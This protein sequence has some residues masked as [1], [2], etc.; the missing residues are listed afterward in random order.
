MPGVTGTSTS[1][2][3]RGGERLL[4]GA[5]HLVAVLDPGRVDAV[6]LGDRGDVELGQVEAGR[7][8][9]LLD[10]GEP[11]ED[12]VLLVAH[13]QEGDRHL[14][15]DGAP[16]GA[17]RVLDRAL[18]D[19]A[20]DRA[21]GLGE[22]HADRGG[23]AE[24]EAAAGGEVVAAGAREAQLVA[25]GE[26]AGGRL[27]HDDPVLGEDLAERGV[28]GRGVERVGG[29]D[30]LRALVRLG[31]RAGSTPAPRRAAPAR[32]SLTSATSASPIGARAASSG[33]LVI[34]TSFAPSGSSGP[35]M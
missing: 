23:E 19:H 22:L 14:V 2:G 29:R 18:A 5:A 31:H 11:L 24:A 4:Q 20:D 1:S 33:S 30:F 34:A 8:G 16:E 12:R 26:G 6:A 25:Q 35:G 27:E 28:H 3:L 21:V 32:V 17:D 9:D 10:L 7:A 13:D 15:G